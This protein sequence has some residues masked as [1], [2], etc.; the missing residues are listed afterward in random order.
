MSAVRLPEVPPGIRL[1]GI[2]GAPGVGKST[3]AAALRR[4][5]GLAILPMDGF[6]YADVE[7]VRRGLLDRKGAPE[8]FDAEGYAALL[9][10]VR[11][12]EAD[13]VAPMFER[14]LEQPLAGAIPVPATGTVVTEGNYLLLD[15]PRW[16]AVREQLDVVWHLVLDQTVRVERLVARHVAFGK[17]P[18][19]A[20]AWVMR[21]DRA[22]A[23][24]VEA[25]RDRADLVVEL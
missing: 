24:L 8:T 20:R 11:A 4:Q 10:R 3:V 1:L 14:D 5:L 16:R 17:T 7:L 25:C 23:R 15:E 19:A 2:T 6:H 21:V 22:N 13:V 18:E 12:G 9:R